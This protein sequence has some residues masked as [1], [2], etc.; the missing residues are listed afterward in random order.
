MSMKNNGGARRP[1]MTRWTI[2]R[3]TIGSGAPVEVSTMSTPASA[4]S[5]SANGTA[6][7]GSEESRAAE[8]RRAA[9]AG[10]PGT[11]VEASEGAGRGQERRGRRRAGAAV[12][13]ER[14]ER[15]RPRLAR[16]LGGPVDLHAVARGKDQR[17]LHHA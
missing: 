16:R 15:D 13:A 3:V 6:A 1:C 17:V 11:V 9:A 2:A 12:A 14:A 8:A 7:P 5:S 10:G 4:T